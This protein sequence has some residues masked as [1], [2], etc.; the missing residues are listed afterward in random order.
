M[1]VIPMCW[2]I[3]IHVQTGC[4]L[5]EHFVE[6]VGSYP[7]NMMLLNQHAIGRLVCDPYLQI[8]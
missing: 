1:V 2:F 4:G 8:F 6:V 5:N 3:R 7:N